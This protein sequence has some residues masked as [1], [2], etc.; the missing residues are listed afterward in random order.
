MGGHPID[1]G[2]FRREL[3]LLVQRAAHECSLPPRACRATLRDSRRTAVVL[4]A[5]TAHP[6]LPVPAITSPRD[7]RHD[8]LVTVV[9]GDAGREKKFPLRPSCDDGSQH[10]FSATRLSHRDRRA[11]WPLSSAG[12]PVRSLSGTTGRPRLPASSSMTIGGNVTCG[13][14]DPAGA[15]PK[16]SPPTSGS[17][18]TSWHA[19]SGAVH[20]RLR[21]R[22][23]QPAGAP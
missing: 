3:D 22:A 8:C 2:T 4:A 14:L 20:V 1:A 7:L 13:H 9:L 21:G 6:D 18:T 12:W 16:L 11:R 17:L 19:R 10:I 15:G 23:P 5:E